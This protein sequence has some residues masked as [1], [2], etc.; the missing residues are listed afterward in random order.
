MS[1]YVFEPGMN[2][3]EAL[4]AEYD[5]EARAFGW[6]KRSFLIAAPAFAVV[7][8]ALFV[9]TFPGP[10]AQTGAER[11]SLLATCAPTLFLD[12]LPAVLYIGFVPAG[13]IWAVRYIRRNRLFVFGGIGYLA[14]CF[15]A[16]IGLPAAFSPV[17]FLAQW[18]KV[19]RLKKRLG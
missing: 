12:A 14:L 10:E 1:E 17:L 13:Y 8:A 19:A 4:R 7:L 15:V 9:L 3:R 2:A 18:I 6:M 11:M 16:F 5:R